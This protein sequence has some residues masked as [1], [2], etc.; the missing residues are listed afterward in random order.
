MHLIQLVVGLAF[1]LP[2]N[3]TA[4]DEGSL[5]ALLPDGHLAEVHVP[6]GK[7]VWDSELGQRIRSAL[8][9]QGAFHELRQGIAALRLMTGTDPVAVIELILGGELE[10]GVYPKPRKH[11]DKPS[12]RQRAVLVI[13]RTGN[14]E[15]LAVAMDALQALLA[16]NPDAKVKSA[17]YRKQPYLRVVS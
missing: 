10:L 8:D 4:A 16:N 13:A 17:R 12:P 9:E 2:S 11:S 6:A 3:A 5:A 15:G 7:A 1:V 14:A